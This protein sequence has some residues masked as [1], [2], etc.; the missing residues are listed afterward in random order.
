[1]STQP[2][3]LLTGEEYLAI[4]RAAPYKSEYYHGEMFAM[5]GASRAHNRLVANLVG[6]LN[7]QT[8]EGPCEAYASDMRVHIPAIQW[9]TYP[10]ASTACD[11]Q[12][13][14]DHVDVLLNPVLIAEVLSESTEGYDRGRKFELYQ[15]ISSLKEYLLV[16][17]DHV[18]VELYSRQVDGRWLQTVANRLDDVLVIGSACSRLSLADLYKKVELEA[19]PLRSETAHP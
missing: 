14:D 18:R 13:G 8:I 16:S 15:S 11:P 19:R 9:Y 2:K 1:M 6:I 4:E 3:P 17:S 10:D 5:A 7:E 12:F